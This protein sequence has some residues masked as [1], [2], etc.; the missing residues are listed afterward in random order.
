MRSTFT[1][2]GKTS[3][4]QTGGTVI[5]RGDETE[6]GEV[7]DYDPVFSIPHPASTFMMTGG[8]I[9]FRDR[10]ANTSSAGNGLYLACDPGNYSV[11]GGKIIFETNPANSPSIDL[12]S[13]PNLW[14]LEVRRLGSSGTS[15]VN[16]LNDLTVTNTINIYNNGT[17]SSGVGNF[18]VIISNDFMINPGGTYTPNNNTTTFTGYGNYF[19]WNYGTITNGLYNL[20]VNKPLGSLIL[21]TN[22]GSFTVRN[23]LMIT[24]GMLADGGKT[25]YVQGNVINNGTVIGAG[26]IVMSSAVKS[27]TISGNGSGKFQNLE[28][29]NTNGAAGSAQVSLAADIGITGV[30]T[31]TND[32]LFDISRYELALTAIATISG[33]MS[34]NRFILT[35]GAPSDGGL[36]W[37]YA[38]TT[39]FFYPVGSG[40][41]Y[42]PVSIH[43][44]KKPST[45]GSVAVKPVPSIHPFVTNPTS[46][47]Y[48]WKVEEYDFSGIQE[49][50]ISLEFHYGSL[51]DNAQYVPGKYVPAYWKYINDPTLVNETN[52]TILFPSEKTFSGDFTAGLPA[53]FGT[54]TTFYSRASG[55]WSS[56]STWST[57]GHGGAA[58]STIPGANNPVFIGDGASYNHTVTV[59][60][61][62]VFSGSI[63]IR[64]GS[65]LDI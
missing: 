28:I 12:N 26:K 2:S 27:Q 25:V 19:L 18:P 37:T 22:T 32:R 4:V 3:Y 42:T 15:V 49:D 61:G 31:L 43:L 56:P 13:N 65:I 9:I 58:S 20:E 5:I 35:S 36:R 59:S 1:A 14:N 41:S 63:A 62:S 8:E 33:T 23:N 17:L 30:L 46:M 54:V 39:T 24:N 50:G 57:E 10:S 53:S 51:P 21:A 7:R 38:D 64:T 47:P 52:N 48:Y 55:E 11:T 45:F 44:K 34:N 6:P 60:S 40:T 16:L 29:Y